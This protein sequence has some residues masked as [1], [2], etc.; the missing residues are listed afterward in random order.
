MAGFS[1]VKFCRKNP[2]VSNGRKK[3]PYKASIP[4]AIGSR[5]ETFKLNYVPNS[6]E[7]GSLECF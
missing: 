6:H 7:L 3:N 5:E 4:S 2:N 1:L